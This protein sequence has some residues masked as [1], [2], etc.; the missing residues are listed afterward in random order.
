MLQQVSWKGQWTTDIRANVLAGMTATLALV[1]DS[2]AFSFMAGVPPV[3]GIYATICILLVITFMGGRPGMI[4]A[5]AG[6]MSVLMLSLVHAHGIQYLFAATI[7]TGVIQLLMGVFKLGKL[8]RFVPQGVLTGFINAL[9]IMIFMSQLRYFEGQ[10]WLMYAL[11]GATLAIIYW[12]PRY[13]K[14]IPSPLAA[15]AVLSVAVWAFGIADVTRIGDI[16]AI[17][18]SLPSFLIPDIP[19]NWQTLAI[20]APYSLSLAV[21]GYTETMLTHSLL[22]EMTGE[23][24]DKNREMRGQGVA[25]VVAGFFGGMAGCALVAE[26]VLNV[27]MGGKHRLSTLVAALFLLLLTVLLGDVLAMIPMAALVGIM[28]MVCVSIFDW[29]SVFKLKKVPAGETVVMAATVA[30]VLL[31]HDL[32]IGVGVGVLLSFIGFAIRASKLEVVSEWNGKKR[33]YRVEGQLFFASASSLEEK[34]ELNCE[35]EEVHLDLTASK[36]WDHTASLAINRAVERLQGNGKRVTVS[37]LQ[38]G[39]ATDS[40]SKAA[41]G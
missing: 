32:A 33:V 3:V 29:K 21:V 18:A 23:R 1:P 39:T 31:T 9:A 38:S 2:L 6:S 22:D 7:L 17:D 14:A 41:A 35:A 5:A 30:A 15:V 28:L 13:F 25:N 27:K 4:S 8:M 20:I 16:A 19:L 34:I 36:V 37:R 40:K 12:L 11:V 10:S 26:S 24:T